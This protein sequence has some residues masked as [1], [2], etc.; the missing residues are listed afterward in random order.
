MR[1]ERL[2]YALNHRIEH[3]VWGGMTERE[4][5]ALVR[6]RPTVSRRPAAPGTPVPPS[7]D[8]IFGKGG[9]VAVLGLDSF[10][11]YVI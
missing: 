11:G 2:A 6:R 9:V 5:H 4:R 1:T 8:E 3:G 10:C 7:L